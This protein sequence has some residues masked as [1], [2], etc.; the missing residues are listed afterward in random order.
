MLIGVSDDEK[1]REMLS[2]HLER[3]IAK[4][5]AEGDDT[6]T[7]RTCRDKLKAAL[8]TLD[9]K[10]IDFINKEIPRISRIAFLCIEYME[11]DEDVNGTPATVTVQQE[12]L[13][14]EP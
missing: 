13:H 9:Q 1:R 12:P 6:L 3:I 8:G 11:N 2:L 14:Q 5:A 10:D 4:A 7:K